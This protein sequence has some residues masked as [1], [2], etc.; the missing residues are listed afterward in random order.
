MHEH[1]PQLVEVVFDD[2][3]SSVREF[4]CTDCQASWFE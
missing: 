2:G 1:T 3:G 4:T